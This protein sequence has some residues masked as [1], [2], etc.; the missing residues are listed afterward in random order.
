MSTEGEKSAL[1]TRQIILKNMVRRI[2]GQENVTLHYCSWEKDVAPNIPL[3]LELEKNSKICQIFQ[4]SGDEAVLSDHQKSLTQILNEGE[5]I[6]SLSRYKQ[7]TMK[8]FGIK[9][10][11]PTNAEIQ[12]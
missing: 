12:N 7:A 8:L 11:L 1:T 10:D 6:N 3:Q 4:L 9:D 2:V 5:D